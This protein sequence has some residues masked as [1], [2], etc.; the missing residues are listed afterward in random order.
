MHPE[1]VKF[2]PDPIN[3]GVYVG[4]NAADT[5]YL[6]SPMPSIPGKGTVAST[7]TPVRVAVPEAHLAATPYAKAVIN[8]GGKR[9]L[10]GADGIST[11]EIK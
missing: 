2:I 7:I 3:G 11:S 4:S 9:Y 8:Y 1:P 6:P 10:V 5:S